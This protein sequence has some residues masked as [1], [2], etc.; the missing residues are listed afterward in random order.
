M[1]CH[2]KH[3]RIQTRPNKAWQNYIDKLKMATL[4]KQHYSLQDKGG[5]AAAVMFL[6][7]FTAVRFASAGEESR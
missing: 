6:N 3:E 7:Y 1:D 5:R 2:G 4:W